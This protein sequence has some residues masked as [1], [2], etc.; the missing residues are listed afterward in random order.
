MTL[1]AVV[2]GAGWAGEGHTIALRAAGVDVVA[3]CGRTPEPAKAMAAKLGV[4]DVRFDWRQALAELRPDIV[5]IATPA[6]PHREM[7][8]FAAQLSCHILCDKPLGINA[9]EG[10]AML[11]AVAHAGVKHA[12]A[13]SSRYDPFF[14]FAHQLLAEG[15]IGRVR[16]VESLQH[17]SIPPLAPYGWVHSLNLGGGMLN[18]VFTHKLSQVCYITQGTVTA[19]TGE[20]KRLL[21]RAPVGEAIHDFRDTFVKI[22]RRD[23]NTQWREVDADLAYTVI[24][25]IQMPDGGIASG[26]FKSSAMA[27]GRNAGYLAVYG[28]RGTLHLSDRF[29]PGK[30]EHFDIAKG[31]WQELSV[32]PH[33]VEA[34][35]QVENHVQR[36]WN[37]L[38]REFVAD[39]QGD[40]ETTYPTFHDG[41]VHNQVI[42]AVR[43]G[44]SWTPIS[45]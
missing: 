40:G 33:I 5:S 19:A 18:N 7:A 30:L 37:Q 15:L 6:G 10:Q 32:P 25:Q 26:L 20:A 24:T 44:R 39:I 23:P 2:I 13:A 28:E 21:D 11:A 36:D 43:S 1:R 8:E 12:Y 3:L 31:E 35:P 29:G 4:E 45:S 38:C 14:L 9:V 22:V 41:W 27:Q 34:L 42:D 17:M 16:E